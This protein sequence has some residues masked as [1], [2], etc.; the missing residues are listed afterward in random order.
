MQEYA[1]EYAQHFYLNPNAFVKMSGLWCLRLGHN[2]AK[3]NYQVGPRRIE[4][5]SFHFVVEGRLLLQFED[6]EEILHSGD[7]VCFFPDESYSYRIYEPDKPL[8][9]IWIAFQG[10]QAAPLLQSLGLTPAA[11]I[12]RARGSDEIL[13]KA[14]ALLHHVADHSDRVQDVGFTLALQEKL[15]AIFA[16]LLHEGSAHRAAKDSLADIPWLKRSLD[17]MQLHYMEGISVKEIAEAAGVHRSYFSDIFK[18][19]MGESPNRYLYRLKMEKAALLIARRDRNITEV[20]Y[21][22]GYPSLYSF[23]RAY[24]N[25]FGHSPGSKP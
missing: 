6:R 18:K 23:S 8:K 13:N 22:V 14:V 11:P 5:Y 3:P 7:M 25:Y 4:C 9:L 19:M 24:R 2:V 1:H 17:F 20:A 12:L 15:Y 10:P 16:L 21:T